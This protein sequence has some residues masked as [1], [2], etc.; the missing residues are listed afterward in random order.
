M[1]RNT[2]RAGDQTQSIPVKGI[3]A[4]KAGGEYYRYANPCCHIGNSGITVLL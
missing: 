2:V 4:E 3:G 1:E